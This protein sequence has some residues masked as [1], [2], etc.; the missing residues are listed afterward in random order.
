M[1]QPPFSAL[2]SIAFCADHLLKAKIRSIMSNVMS[3]L[4]RNEPHMTVGPRKI[5]TAESG[6]PFATDAPSME[7]SMIADHANIP[8]LTGNSGRRLRNIF[9]LANVIG[10][11]AVALAVRLLLF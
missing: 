2:D 4:A 9:I 11:I 6:S 3:P 8:S 10:W 1:H 7:R 5:D